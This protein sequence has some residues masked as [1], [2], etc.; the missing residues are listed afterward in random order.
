MPFAVRPDRS[1]RELLSAAA[2]D[3]TLR[4]RLKARAQAVLDEWGVRA[5]GQTVYFVEPGQTPAAGRPDEVFV[6]L[7]EPAPALDDHALDAVAGGWDAAHERA[8]Q[9]VDRAIDTVAWASSDPW[10]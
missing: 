5:P 2:V 6:E 7:P 9:A 8:V 4:L 3:P 10:V 1:L